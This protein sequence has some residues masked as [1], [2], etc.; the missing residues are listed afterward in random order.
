MYGNRGP[1]RWE[2]P[3]RISKLADKQDFEV[4]DPLR[5]EARTWIVTA[6]FDRDV[7]I[8]HDHEHIHCGGR[9]ESLEPRF[10]VSNLRS[11]QPEVMTA[12]QHRRLRGG[13][14]EVRRSY[15]KAAAWTNAI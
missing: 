13:G 3:A 10:L 14:K 2:E 4:A 9:S 15:A 7:D 6:P 8:K 1:R 11:G 5:C 12:S